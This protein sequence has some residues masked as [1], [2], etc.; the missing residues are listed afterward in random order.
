MSKT[1]KRK[2]LRKISIEQQNLKILYI[3]RHFNPV[4]LGLKCENFLYL[5]HQ[6]TSKNTTQVVGLSL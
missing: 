5:C 6:Q 1:L 2:A 4:F 3:L